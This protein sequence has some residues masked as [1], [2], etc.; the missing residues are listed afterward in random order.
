MNVVDSCVLTNS[1]IVVLK[2]WERKR[3]AVLLSLWQTE[4]LPTRSLN[5]MWL[6]E[7]EREKMLL[8]SH[9]RNKPTLKTIIAR[10]F[11]RLSQSFFSLCCA[12]GLWVIW[13]CYLTTTVSSSSGSLTLFLF[14]FSLFLF[15]SLLPYTHSH[16]NKKDY[17]TR[18]AWV[19]WSRPQTVG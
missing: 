15:L 16:K 12:L 14:S 11:R 8:P 19:T 6:G 18:I 17:E 13:I 7:R 3:K 4:M 9:A 5:D 1:K 2:K 10:L